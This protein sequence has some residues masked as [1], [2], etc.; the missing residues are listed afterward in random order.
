MRFSA[1]PYGT[2]AAD[3]S[4]GERGTTLLEALVSL[5]IL[6]SV[7]IGGAQLIGV[8]V[9]VNRAS[10]DITNV[11]A[12]AERRLEQLRGQNYAA[13]PVGGSVLADLP[14]FFDSLDTDGDGVTDYSRRWQV[15]DSGSSKTI[16]VRVLSLLQ[17]LGASKEARISLL[18]AQ[19]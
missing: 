14:G 8:S 13:I 15:T 5:L 3:E 4:T 18:V 6:T 9:L 1:Y 2:A 16:E 19:Q 17:V 10:A 11:T 12:L 7:L